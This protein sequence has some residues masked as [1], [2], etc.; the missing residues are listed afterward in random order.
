MFG[1]NSLKTRKKF[2][3]TL[4]VM[5]PKIAASEDVYEVTSMVRAILELVPRDGVYKRELGEDGKIFAALVEVSNIKAYKAKSIECLEYLAQE[6]VN[7]VK[8]I[9]D[10]S[11]E[12]KEK[13]LKKQKEAIKAILSNDIPKWEVKPD[14]GVEFTHNGGLNY[15]LQFLTGKN[16]GYR[17]ETQDY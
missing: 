5:L 3:A 10:I 4:E 2:L 15:I 6:S 9:E 14:E 17:L 8:R 1:V 13:L 12:E 7:A 11:P 16:D